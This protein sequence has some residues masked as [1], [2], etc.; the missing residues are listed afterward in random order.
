MALSQAPYLA[1]VALLLAFVPTVQ[2]ALS[3]TSEQALLFMLAVF[4]ADLAVSHT[5]AQLRRAMTSR[6]T[7]TCPAQLRCRRG[8]MLARAVRRRRSAATCHTIRCALTGHA[9]P[10]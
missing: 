3:A 4:V 6:L 5:G 2:S 10:S 9:S 8:I 7:L 1:A